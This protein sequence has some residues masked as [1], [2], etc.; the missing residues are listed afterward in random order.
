MAQALF[1]FSALEW[2]EPYSKKSENATKA[3]TLTVTIM[4]VSTTKR[5]LSLTYLVRMRALLRPAIAHIDLP[6]CSVIGPIFLTHNGVD[7]TLKNDRISLEVQ[8]KHCICE[9]HEE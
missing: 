1:S 6:R 7:L 9:A 4:L 5:E 2:Y 3:P 8:I